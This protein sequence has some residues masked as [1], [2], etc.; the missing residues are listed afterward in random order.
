[1]ASSARLVSAIIRSPYSLPL[2]LPQTASADHRQRVGHSFTTQD[3]VVFS[4]IG[5]RRHGM[6][7]RFAKTVF[8]QM[9]GLDFRSRQRT[10]REFFVTI[11][12]DT[13]SCLSFRSAPAHEHHDAIA[14]R[15]LHAEAP[16]PVTRNAQRRMQAYGMRRSALVVYGCD[17]PDFVRVLTPRCS[18]L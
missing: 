18:C 9:R 6:S 4:R 3:Q 5:K 2:Q 12:S 11:E 17:D 8:C 16:L 15:A 13:H 10:L 1:M 7:G 14:G